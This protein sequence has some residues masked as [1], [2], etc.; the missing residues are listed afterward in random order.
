MRLEGVFVSYTDITS[1]PRASQSTPSTA[2]ELGSW[3]EQKEAV[4]KL[5]IHIYGGYTRSRGFQLG[6]SRA[7]FGARRGPA[8]PIREALGLTSIST[9][10]A[11]HVPASRKR[12]HKLKSKKWADLDAFG[13]PSVTPAAKGY[14]PGHRSSPF[15]RFGAIYGVPEVSRDLSF[16]LYH[17]PFYQM[18][19]R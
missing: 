4:G 18:T 1:S 16:D 14:A 19:L 13:P 8:R 7:H 12:S 17:Q 6:A 11:L 2:L 5:V 15:H 10:T 9:C 3:V